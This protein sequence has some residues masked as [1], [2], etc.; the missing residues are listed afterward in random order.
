M[1]KEWDNMTTA[2]NQ[3]KEM[4]HMEVAM[5]KITVMIHN[6]SMVHNNHLM[7]NLDLI[8]AVKAHTV[9]IA[10]IKPRIKNMNVEQ[11]P[12]KASL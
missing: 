8:T 4:I 3:H 12:L 7:T 11:V 2:T 5:T 9:T 10:I 6:Q 1:P